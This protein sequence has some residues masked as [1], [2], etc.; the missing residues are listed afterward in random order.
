[1]I[2]S[3]THSVS[4]VDGETYVILKMVTVGNS[5]T[6]LDINPVTNRIYVANKDSNTTTVIDGKSNNV[7]TNIPVGHSPSSVGVNPKT[8]EIF[9]TNRGFQLMAS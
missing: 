1:M 6:G 2:S 3:L 8:N 4:V 5:P 9:V 7:V